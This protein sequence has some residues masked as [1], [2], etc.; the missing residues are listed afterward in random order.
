LNNKNS[1]TAMSKPL[2]LLNVFVALTV[3]MNAPLNK[4][5]KSPSLVVDFKAI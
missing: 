1:V 3:A 2:Y 4:F 5:R